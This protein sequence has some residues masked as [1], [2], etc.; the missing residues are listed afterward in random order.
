MCLCHQAHKMV[1]AEAGA[2]KDTP[3]DE[4]VP[5]PWSRSISRCLAEATEVE[6]GGA[7]WALLAPEELYVF[8]LARRTKLTPKMKGI[9]CARLAA[10]TCGAVACGWRMVAAMCLGC[11]C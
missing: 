2:Q 7:L 11:C 6:V 3:C 8:T 10:T 5:H 4:T 1:L 9:S